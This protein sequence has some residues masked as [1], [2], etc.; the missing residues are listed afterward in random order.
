MLQSG[1]ICLGFGFG[2]LSGPGIWTSKWFHA[3]TV[4]GAG[5]GIWTS[6][7]FGILGSMRFVKPVYS[8]IG[9]TPFCYGVLSSHHIVAGFLG[10]IIGLW[11]TSSRPGPTIYKLLYLGNVE[12]VLSSSI[13]AVFFTALIFLF[14]GEA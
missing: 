6:D 1:P 12:E 13:A 3:A 10:I 8:V 7:S 11:H 2:H 9:F 5:P 4:L 14:E